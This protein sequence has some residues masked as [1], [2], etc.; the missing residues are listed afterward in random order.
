MNIN[1]LYSILF[2]SAS[3]L[4]TNCGETPEGS[5]A[6]QEAALQSKDI[7]NLLETATRK[8]SKMEEKRNEMMSK[9]KANDA[10]TSNQTKEVLTF[11]Q[12]IAKAEGIIKN[13]KTM[14]EQHEV[15]LKKHENTALGVAEIQAQHSQINEDFLLAKKEMMELDKL[16]H[17]LLLEHK[18]MISSK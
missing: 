6:H 5:K 14:I 13:L 18:K 3:F 1:I 15:Y 10:S 8:L 4:F 17:N 11:N 12:S 16:Y 9:I 7:K 2:L